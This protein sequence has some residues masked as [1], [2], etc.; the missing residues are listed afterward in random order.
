MR[1]LL[2]TMLFVTLSGNATAAFTCEQIKDKVTRASCIQERAMKE[3]SDVAARVKAASEEKEKVIK[4]EKTKEFDDFVQKSKEV[5]TRNFKDPTAALFTN[6]TVSENKFRKSLCGS[7]NGKNSYG[8]YIGAN[9]FSVTWSGKNVP[10]IWN[11]FESAK[12]LKKSLS[13]MDTRDLE[14][15]MENLEA[16]FYDGNCGPSEH[17]T[18]T[19][20]EK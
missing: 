13:G 8:A 18:I 10:E 20:V 7:V 9:R 16:S 12:E 19:K 3:E 5:L 1:V 2:I 14:K 4:A 6:L 17:N 15:S 11:E